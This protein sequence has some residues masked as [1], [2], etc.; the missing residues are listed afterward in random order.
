VSTTDN[1][2]SGV[3]GSLSALR[4]KL[5][6]QGVKYLFGAYVD[7]YGVPKAKCVPLNHLEDMAAGSERYTVGGLEGMGELGPHEDE[8]LGIPDLDSL[9]ILPWDRR[10][11]LA[12]AYL[13]FAGAP[14]SH[15]SR[16]VLKT[17]LDK[18]AEL[19]Y[20]VNLGVEPEFYVLEEGA[21][22][23]FGL[24]TKT[25]ALNLPTRAYDVEATMLADRFLEP[26][27]EYMNE[28]GWDVYSFDHEGGDSQFEFDFSYCS[29]MEMAD[30]M[31][32]F[33]LM[34]KHVA[35]TLGCIATFMPKPFSDSFGSGAHM[36]MSLVD[37]ATGVNVFA[38][39]ANSAPGSRG[40]HTAD[41]YHFTAGL[42]RHAGALTALACSTVNSY[43]R[44]LPIGL[45]N[46]ISWAPVYRGYGDNNRTLMCRL[47]S[48]RHCIELRIADSGSNFYLVAAAMLAAGLEGIRQRLEPGDPVNADTYQLGD[49]QLAA[50]GVDRLPQNLGEALDELERDE[51]IR[52]VLGTEFHSSF[53]S[54][55]RAEW[56][57]YNTV[58]GDWER[59]QYLHLW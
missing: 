43:K 37:T 45:M 59:E 27:I 35:R 29:A 21:D 31:L 4:E 6:E 2:L 52:E 18:A 13:E 33:R 54:A 40:G 22:G 16:Y 25:D 12:P 57:M 28:L 5:R 3:H 56:R 9:I 55:K 46:E 49:A 32:I 47:P 8:C 41:A 30:R 53:I 48:N 20:G 11:A 36:N 19:G 42:L 39:E 1:S 24:W 15:D 7:V 17:Q 10:Y 44:L 50:A 26:M 23:T 34:A 58:V 51:L 38:D 14:Y